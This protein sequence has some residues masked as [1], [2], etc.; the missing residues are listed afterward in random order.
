MLSFTVFKYSES[1][2]VMEDSQNTHYFYIKVTL[3][4]LT[5]LYSFCI[6]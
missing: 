3:T 6:I 2:I 5:F 4:S 1:Q